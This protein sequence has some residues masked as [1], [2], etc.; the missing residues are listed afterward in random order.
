MQIYLSGRPQRIP[1]ED[2]NEFRKKTAPRRDDILFGKAASTG[3]IARVK[4]DFEFS[5]WSP[6]ALIRP[7]RSQVTSGFLEY[8]LKDEAAQAQIETLCTLNTQKNI[9]MDDIPKLIVSFPSIP[10]QSMIVRFLDTQDRRINRLIR[11]KRRLIELLNEQKQAI[12]HRA[13]TLWP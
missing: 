1:Q 10:E 12:I 8:S 4:V 2:R 13:V 7:D 3:K 6:L 11:I 9:S 5:I